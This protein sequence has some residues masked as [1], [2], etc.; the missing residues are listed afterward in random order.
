MILSE[1][2]IQFY[3]KL[4]TK[5]GASRVDVKDEILDTRGR[6]VPHRISMAVTDM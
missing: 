3:N 6:F 2:C 1:F 4:F 5:S